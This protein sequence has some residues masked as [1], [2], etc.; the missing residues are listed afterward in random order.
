MARQIRRSPSI[1]LLLVASSYVTL[2]Y[3]T[4]PFSNT[5]ETLVLALSA[6]VL[7]KIIQ[8]YDASTTLLT[9]STS[10]ATTAFHPSATS[11]SSALTTTGPHQPKHSSILLTFLLGV[12]F[13]IGI[14]TRITFAVF[15]FPFGIMLLYLNARASFW[16]GRPMYVGVKAAMAI[17]V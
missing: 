5:V 1:A 11:G 7:G 15:G 13:A 2:A 10:K 12:L 17:A 8:E 4:H 3:H 9:A 14:F 16:K 6:V